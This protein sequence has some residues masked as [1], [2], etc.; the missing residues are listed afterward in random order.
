MAGGCA[1]GPG[2]HLSFA[3][4]GVDQCS[5]HVEG[6]GDV[7]NGLPFFKGVLGIMSTENKRVKERT[8]VLLL[9]SQL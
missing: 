3:K 4:Q 9:V 5:Q 7:K 1:D 6:S 8:L 2:L